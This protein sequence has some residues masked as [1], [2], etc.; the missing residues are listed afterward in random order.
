[1]GMSVLLNKNAVQGWAAFFALDQRRKASDGPLPSNVI[2]KTFKS[3]SAE[4]N[5][6]GKQLNS[7]AYYVKMVL[8]LREVFS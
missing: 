7:A 6:S 4:Y 1:M 5:F 3:I 8:D 2:S